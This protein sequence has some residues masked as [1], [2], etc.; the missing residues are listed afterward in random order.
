MRSF[1]MKRTQ[2][3]WIMHSTA[4]MLE[5]ASFLSF[6]TNRLTG[7]RSNSFPVNPVWKQL[8]ASWDPKDN[9]LRAYDVAVP[10]FRV[11]D[12]LST[13]FICKEIIEKLAE[14]NDTK[15]KAIQLL[16]SPYN[17]EIEGHRGWAP[18]EAFKETLVRCAKIAYALP[19]TSKKSLPKR[20]GGFPSD[21]AR[22]RWIFVDIIRRTRFGTILDEGFLHLLEASDNPGVLV[23]IIKAFGRWL[24]LT[25]KDP[26]PQKAQ[27]L[28]PEECSDCH[29]SHH[30][31]LKYSGFKTFGRCN[32]CAMD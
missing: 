5:R 29:N 31:I 23:D 3:Y 17:Q 6:L 28:F 18:S 22:I 21:P 20:A 25:Y 14:Y 26:S 7:E 9:D 12:Y 11:A 16:L 32:Y 2:S 4:F 27:F 24:E 8:E 15:G 30:D 13:E 1:S 19:K 10:L